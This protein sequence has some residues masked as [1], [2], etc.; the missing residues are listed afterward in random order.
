MNDLA[1]EYPIFV[2]FAIAIG[3]WFYSWLTKPERPQKIPDPER[4]CARCKLTV[5]GKA[6]LEYRHCP[7][8]GARYSA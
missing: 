6:S 3:V 2:V 8:C 5:K 7:F 4:L 1:W